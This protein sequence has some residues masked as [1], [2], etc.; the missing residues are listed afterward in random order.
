MKIKI[1]IPSAMFAA[2]ICAAMAV[3]SARA[4]DPYQYILT[5]DYDP[6]VASL[7]ESSA[8]SSEATGFSTGTV[9]ARTAAAPLEAR[10]RTW[11]ESVGIALRSDLLKGLLMIIR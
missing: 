2:V 7:A 1:N 9:A 10:F 11:L 3:L 8:A 5:P 6:A 4:D